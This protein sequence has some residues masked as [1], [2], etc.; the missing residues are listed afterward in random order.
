MTEDPLK[1]I[2]SIPVAHG[3][4][5][6][7]QQKEESNPNLALLSFDDL[8]AS[9]LGIDYFL[10]HHERFSGLTSLDALKLID[11]LD[12][13]RLSEF[14]DVLRSFAPLD[15]RVAARFLGLDW[16]DII[17]EHPDQFL[18][19]GDSIVKIMAEDDG[20]D[21]MT[22]EQILPLIKTPVDKR[23]LF[24]LAEH[25]RFDWLRAFGPRLVENY[26]DRLLVSECVKMDDLK[27]AINY[28]AQTKRENEIFSDPTILDEI[29]RQRAPNSFKI[30]IQFMAGEYPVDLARAVRVMAFVVLIEDKQLESKIMKDPGGYFKIND[31]NEFAEALVRDGQ[32]MLVS[33]WLRKM[34]AL[35][36]VVADALIGAGLSSRV[37]AE[38]GSFWPVI[39]TKDRLMK[40]ADKQA[41]GVMTILDLPHNILKFFQQGDKEWAD[42]M[43]AVGWGAWVLQVNHLEDNVNDFEVNSEMID[44][45]LQVGVEA[46]ENWK[47]QEVDPDMDSAGKLFFNDDQYEKYMNVFGG[48][49]HQLPLTL[50]AKQ[51]EILWSAGGEVWIMMHPEKVESRFF[52]PD[53]LDSLMKTEEGCSIM[54]N[55]IATVQKLG[56][57]PMDNR[58][59]KHLATMLNA[60]ILWDSKKYFDQLIYNE[61]L[62]LFLLKHGLDHELV[63]AGERFPPFEDWKIYRRLFENCY[64]KTA[65]TLEI[66]MK[67]IKHHFPDQLPR[68]LK[69]LHFDPMMVSRV[70]DDILVLEQHDHEAEKKYFI[71][72]QLLK[73]NSVEAASDWL[74]VFIKPEF[75]IEVCRYMNEAMVRLVGQEEWLAAAELLS[76]MDRSNIRLDKKI[77][78][79]DLDLVQKI[80][81]EAQI[82]ANQEEQKLINLQLALKPNN[83]SV[84]ARLEA[85]NDKKNIL[86]RALRQKVIKEAEKEKNR[87]ELREPQPYYEAGE[88]NVSDQVA[89]Y[90]FG[91]YVRM[92]T[93]QVED[94]LLA[95][96]QEL[97]FEVRMR[98]GEV[99]NND[100]LSMWLRDYLVASIDNEL[101]H[102]LTSESVRLLV[103]KESFSGAKRIMFLK[104]STIEEV[105]SYIDRVETMFRDPHIWKKM[106]LYGG[107]LW[108]AVAMWTKKLIIAMQGDSEDEIRHAI[109]TIFSLQHNTNSIM[110]KEV[111][112]LTPQP[113]CSQLKLLLDTKFESVKIVDHLKTI[114]RCISG[115]AQAR[116]RQIL[117]VL[118][119]LPGYDFEN[120]RIRADINWSTVKGA[121]PRGD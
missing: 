9:D 20:I 110:D 103:P 69:Q 50:S 41:A 35:N 82:V 115:P 12:E 87:R 94:L 65:A 60:S 68:L 34:Y 83:P 22:F 109:D 70:D 24:T 86:D 38:A 16:S 102:G 57:I 21:M 47:K 74:A 59:F 1:I 105:I 100:S 51:A 80:S 93:E 26:S 53:R 104:T 8:L 62:A 101:Q 32:I 120:H 92:M 30:F 99:T 58:L 97:S 29:I 5:E 73:M 36:E 66:Q 14:V 113:N 56:V 44:R 2:N 19:L 25:R 31:D 37:I 4:V 39:W 23:L 77:L 64:G 117:E 91:E 3:R 28:Y 7:D 90:Y 75:D 78:I 119:D 40:M 76:L 52:T 85:M 96:G 111:D 42:R 46:R 121:K 33:E 114:D 15:N 61:D 88:R 81:R 11:R 89:I 13:E 67:F 98:V 27:S 72:R 95:A 17:L 112:G 45:I 118:K 79:G 54:Y 108:A 84:L 55:N 6:A 116:I 71:L 10:E 48:Q 106:G 49:L 107:P 43:V 18:P 63:V